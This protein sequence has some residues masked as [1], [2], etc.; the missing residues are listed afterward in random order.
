MALV[1]TSSLLEITTIQNWGYDAD[2]LKKK[3]DLLKLKH[4][5]SVSSIVVS[6][7]DRSC[8]YIVSMKLAVVRYST[9]IFHILIEA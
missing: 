7:Q 9:S 5:T 2:K 4:E 1:V 3:N 8:E 6:K